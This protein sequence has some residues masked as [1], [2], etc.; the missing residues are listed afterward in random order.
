MHANLL[1]P[2]NNDSAESLMMISDDLIIVPAGLKNVRNRLGVSLSTPDIEFHIFIAL[3]HGDNIIQIIAE[4][5][6]ITLRQP[7]TVSQ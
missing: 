6:Y 2:A 4:I 7:F 1:P 5:V 3:H